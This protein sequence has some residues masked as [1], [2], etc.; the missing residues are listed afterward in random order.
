MAEI[1]GGSRDEFVTMM[2]KRARQL[3]C[4]RTNFTNPSGLFDENHY[5]TVRDMAV[6]SIEAM[7]NDTFREIVSTQTKKIQI[8]EW[9]F[10]ALG[11]EE[12]ILL[13]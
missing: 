4:T 1:V 6:I 12:L 2:N 11:L 5:T 7:K 13:K 8:N 3:N 9:I 10:H